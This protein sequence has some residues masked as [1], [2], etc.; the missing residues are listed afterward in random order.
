[1]TNLGGG[2]DYSKWDHLGDSDEE[3]E[4]SRKPRVTKLSSPSR[5]KTTSDGQILVLPSETSKSTRTTTNCEPNQDGM[6]PTTNEL[7]I[8]QSNRKNNRKIDEWTRQGGYVSSLNLYWSQDRKLV[9]LRWKLPPTINRLT[10]ITVSWKGQIYAY[11]DRCHAVGSENTAS[12]FIHGTGNLNLFQGTL[13]YPIHYPEHETE[14]D[15]EIERHPESDDPYIVFILFKA[16]PMEGITWNWKRPLTQVLEESLSSP[17]NEKFQSAW[18]EAHAS[19]R[20]KM[21][22]K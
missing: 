12:F 15:W 16:V 2:I 7:N 21:A 9:T 22:R 17:Q 11:N 18:E 14:L 5:I 1:M 20:E 8:L 13:P 6:I 10:D 4:E 19:F 3:G